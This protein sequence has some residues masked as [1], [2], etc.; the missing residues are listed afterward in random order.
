ME[1]TNIAMTPAANDAHRGQEALQDMPTIMFTKT[2]FWS[3][4][5]RAANRRANEARR[6]EEVERW[7]AKHEDVLREAGIT[8][9]FS[10]WE[11]TRN[12]YRRTKWFVDGRP[13]TLTR[14]RSLLN[15]TR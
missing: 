3:P 14:I 15:K 13:T 1:T 4:A 8:V 12:V 10:Y 5:Q 6:R 11:S 9:E 2:F 7:L